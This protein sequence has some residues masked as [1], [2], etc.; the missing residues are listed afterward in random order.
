LYSKIPT[1]A[2]IPPLLVE[3]GEKERKRGKAGESSATLLLDICMHTLGGVQ[4]PRNWAFSLLPSL[5][6]SLSLAGDS[7]A[8]IQFVCWMSERGRG[9]GLAYM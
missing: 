8:R 6:F 2:K 5:R 9:E 7:S 4:L 1:E 3:D